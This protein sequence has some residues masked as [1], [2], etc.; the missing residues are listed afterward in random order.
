MSFVR[1]EYDIRRHGAR[2][3][4][5]EVTGAAQN[6]ED[7]FETVLSG[8]RNKDIKKLIR[9]GH[10]VLKDRQGDHE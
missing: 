4:T 2:P 1:I 3:R 9:A 7:A 6:L 5:V 10:K 8:L